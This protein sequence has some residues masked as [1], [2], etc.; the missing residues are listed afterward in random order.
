[1]CDSP[2]VSTDMPGNVWHFLGGKLDLVLIRKLLK[3]IP[4]RRR[5]AGPKNRSIAISLLASEVHEKKCITKSA[6]IDRFLLNT[7]YSCSN[8]FISNL[9]K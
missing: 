8:Y 7:Y 9:L 1:V 4:K 3:I 5:W 6:I 2:A